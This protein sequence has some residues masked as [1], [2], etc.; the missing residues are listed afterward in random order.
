MPAQT[1]YYV[2]AYI[3]ED[4]TPYYIGKGKGDR[5]Y[6]HKRTTPRPEDVSKIV[7]LEKNLT[8]VGA[9]AIER[10]L[11]EWHGRRLINGGN[12]LNIQEGGDGGT[13]VIG[14][15]CYNNGKVNRYFIEGEQPAG[16]LPGRWDQHNFTKEKQTAKFKQAYKNK[17]RSDVQKQAWIDTIRDK[18]D[19]SKCGKK[20]DE[21][22][23]KRPEVRAKIK[24]AA[25]ADGENRSRRMSEMR[26][27]NKE[28]PHCGKVADASNAKRWHFDNC[29]VRTWQLT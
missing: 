12:L 10:R 26:K 6:S 15:K 16:W 20:G 1:I 29:K 11:I 14:K 8:E 7:I 18:R 25:L 21:N 24:A 19:H 5:A 22:V 4:G 3:R 23:S 13:T 2:Y 17:S 27:I 9:F 28:C